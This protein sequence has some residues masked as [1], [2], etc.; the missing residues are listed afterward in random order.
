MYFFDL[1]KAFIPLLLVLGLLYAVLYFIRKNSL[2]I[3][4]KK[5]T[6]LKIKVLSSQLIFPKKYITLVQIED[7]ILVLGITENGMNV[8]KELDAAELADQKVI[9]NPNENFIDIL[10]KNFGKK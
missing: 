3:G 10:K 8:L 7:K 2:T 1:L 5:G 9:E 4:G 6:L